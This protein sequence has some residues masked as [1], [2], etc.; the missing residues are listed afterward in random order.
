MIS[1][2]HSATA[3]PVKVGLIDY[4]WWGKTIARQVAENTRRLLSGEVLNNLV[5]PL[6]GY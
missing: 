6:L 2:P 5:D 1:Q 3:S 4:G